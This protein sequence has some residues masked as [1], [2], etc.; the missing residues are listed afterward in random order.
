[1]RPSHLDLSP[2]LN[3]HPDPWDSQRIG[4]RIPQHQLM[5]QNYIGARERSYQTGPPAYWEPTSDVDS[6]NGRH[7]PD[8][9]Y[10]TQTAGSIYSEDVA[11]NQECQSVPGGMNEAELHRDNMRL[12]TMYSGGTPIEC[13]E[14]Q[15]QDSALELTCHVCQQRSKNRS[16]LTY[17]FPCS[18][19]HYS[20]KQPRSKHKL[21]HEKPFKCDVEGC[22]RVTEG[23]TTQNDLDRHKKS[24]HNVM[25]GKSYMCAVP[26]CAKKT[27]VWPRADNFRQHCQRLHKDWD[28]NVLIDRSEAIYDQCCNQDRGIDVNLGPGRGVRDLLAIQERNLVL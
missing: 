27:K 6:S 12:G 13:P 4:G 3:S 1:M 7:V 10:Y 14:E 26:H 23:F 25:S 16:E 19:V 18:V 17:V 5:N 2:S 28:L 22:G 8:S 9:G 20:T 11:S 24:L 15:T 21:R